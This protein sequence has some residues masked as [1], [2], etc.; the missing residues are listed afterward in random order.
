VGDWAEA[1]LAA[2]NAVEDGEHARHGARR[3]VIDTEDAR[4]RVRRAHHCRIDL[5]RHAEVV[6]IAAVAGGKPKVLLSGKRFADCFECSCFQSA[7]ETFDGLSSQS[8]CRRP[9]S[10]RHLHWQLDQEGGS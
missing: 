9:D 3:R 4:V 5:S 7:H 2:L 1:I 8:L 10:D 6:G